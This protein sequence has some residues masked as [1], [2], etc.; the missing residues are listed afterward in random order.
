MANDTSPLNLDALHA[1]IEAAIRI[2]FPDFATVEFY[3]S[4]AAD[5]PPMPA[6]LLS[7][8]RCDRSRENLD[9]DGQMKAALRFEARISVAD[10]T[11]GA[12]LQLRS[13]AVALA[14]W[15]HQLGRFPGAPSDAIDVIA[16]LPAATSTTPDAAPAWIVEWTLPVALG[17]SAWQDGDGVTPRASFSF[18]PDIGR[19]HEDDYQPLPERAP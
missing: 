4:G 13:T 1:A 17:R 2:A 19:A 16:A 3:R 12:S 5:T 14:S 7:M 10:S 15:L 6:C 18:A 11:P 8:T 9:G